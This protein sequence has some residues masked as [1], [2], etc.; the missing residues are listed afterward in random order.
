[1]VRQFTTKR[2]IIS[3]FANT[4]NLV[5]PEVQDHHEKVS[6]LAY[7]LAEALDMDEKHRMMAFAGGLLHDIGGIL[8]EG[9]ISLSDLEMSAGQAAAVGASILKTFPVTSPVAVVV[10]E[11]QTPWQRL[12]NIHTD[13]KVT[14]QIGQI[15]HLADAVD[16][17]LLLIAEKVDGAADL[18]DLACR[19]GAVHS[20]LI[21]PKLGVYLAVRIG[22]SEIK[23][24]RALDVQ[25]K[26][27]G[28]NHT[29]ALHLVG[30]AVDNV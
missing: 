6:Y 29:K 20:A 10:R 27:N 2:D 14:H 8:K 1:M 11:S 16:L 13:L 5:S 30:G 4:M 7:R 18:D 25:L 28:F 24:L 26:L 15:V 12:K 3:A 9:N 21:I 22:K 23:I 17:E 19:I